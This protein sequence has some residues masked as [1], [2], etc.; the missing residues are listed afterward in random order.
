MEQKPKYIVNRK[1]YDLTHAKHSPI[2]CLTP[3]LFQSVKPNE[4]KRTVLDVT[5]KYADKTVNFFGR[6]ILDANDMR[7]VQILVA[8]GTK[9]PTISKPQIKSAY[10]NLFPASVINDKTAITNAIVEGQKKDVT[11]IKTSIRNLLAAM[12][13]TGGGKNINTIKTRLMRLS[14]LG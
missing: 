1:V 3:G 10:P 7:L 6:E 9:I 11:V 13:L 8:M 14:F 12:N 2:H 4:R 5:Y